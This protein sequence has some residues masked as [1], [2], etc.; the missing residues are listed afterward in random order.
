MPQQLRVPP[1]I[2][3]TEDDLLE[4]IESL[5]QLKS[6]FVKSGMYGLFLQSEDQATF[7]RL[8]LEAKSLIDDR[9]GA[10]NDYSTLFNAH[11]ECVGGEVGGPSYAGLVR[12]IEI[13]RGVIKRI[14]RRSQGHTAAATSIPKQDPYVDP[15]RI[16]ELLSASPIKW[17]FA[18]LVR[19]CVELN[20]AHEKGHCISV[21]MLVRAIIDHVPPIF[22]KNSFQ[23][24]ASN[25]GGKSFNDS[26]QHLDKSMRK[27]GDAYLHQQ[28]RQRESLPNPV[29]VDV[30]RDLDVLLA[31]I[32]RLA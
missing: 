19:M 1:G 23:E 30:R 21:A 24:V 28:I 25:H 13:L 17:D 5:E 8:Y 32:V 4:V 22:N 11:L 29:Q 6:R 9:L 3:G 2:A 15:S 18:R 20:A 16:D 7:E 14:Q 26:M 31:E 27:I 10:F 12:I